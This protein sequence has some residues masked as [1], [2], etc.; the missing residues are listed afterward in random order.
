MRRQMAKI[1]VQMDVRSTDY[2]RFQ[3]KMRR[4]SAQIFSWGWNADYPDAENFSFSSYGPNAKAKNGGENAANYDSPEY[5]KSFEQM[6]FS[7]D[8][9]EKEASIQRMVAIVQRDAPWMFGYFPMSG[10]AYQQ[11]VGNAKPTQM[12]RNTSQ[13]M[14][15]D[16]V[17]RERK[18]DEWN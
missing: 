1:G 14:K 11:W 9:P 15:I 2:N 13:Y 6:K 17:S 4:G 12:V 16:P 10:G 8:G 7:D 18:I 5:D 3:D